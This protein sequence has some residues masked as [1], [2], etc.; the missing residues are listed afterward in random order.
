MK[1]T[2]EY[3]IDGVPYSKGIEYTDEQVNSMVQQGVFISVTA[4][5]FEDILQKVV[6]DY[7]EV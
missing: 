6:V 5:V 4:R 3:T 7:K 1:I 2:I